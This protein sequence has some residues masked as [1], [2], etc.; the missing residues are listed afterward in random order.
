MDEPDALESLAQRLSGCDIIALDTESNSLYAYRDRVCL[1][2][3]SIPRGDYLVDPLTLTDL[4]SLG[5]VLADPAIEK[6]LHDAKYDVM[7][8]RRDFGFTLNNIFDTMVAS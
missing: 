7:G 6:V 4:S 5:E 3:V 8:L 1:I 2:Q